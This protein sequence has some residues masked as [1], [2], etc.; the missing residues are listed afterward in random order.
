MLPC[1]LQAEAL[2]GAEAGGGRKRSR[3]PRI[4]TDEDVDIFRAVGRGLA[5]QD[6]FGRDAAEQIGRDHRLAQVVDHAAVIKL[7]SLEAG[8]DSDMLDIEG[9]I[10]FRPVAADAGA[11]TRVDRTRTRL[12]S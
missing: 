6:R 5:G 1:A 8:D 10:A 2:A 9:E 11:G 7:A 3:R 4:L 12:N